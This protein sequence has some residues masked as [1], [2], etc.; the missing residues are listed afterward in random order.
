MIEKQKYAV[1]TL[2]GIMILFSIQ[3]LL[4]G[5]SLMNKTNGGDQE[6]LSLDTMP[7][8]SVFD[9]HAF[10]AI[11]VDDNAPQ[12]WYDKTHV[13]TIQEGIDVAAPGHI[14][15]VYP[16]I[17]QE[18]AP[19]SFKGKAITVQSIEGPDHTIITP[20]KNQNYIIKFDTDEQ[21]TSVFKGFT[22]QGN[23]TMKK[24]CGIYCEG[25]SP[26]LYGNVIEYVQKGILIKN[27]SPLIEKNLIR[28]NNAIQAYDIFDGYGG[29]ICIKSNHDGDFSPAIVWNTI[30][31]NS[32]EYCGGGIYIKPFGGKSEILISHTILQNNTADINGGGMH[33]AYVS[34]KLDNEQHLTLEFVNSVLYNNIAKNNGGGAYITTDYENNLTFSDSTITENIA[35]TMESDTDNEGGGIYI[36]TSEPPPGYSLPTM[37]LKNTILYFNHIGYGIGDELGY[38]NAIIHIIYSDIRGFTLNPDQQY[39]SYG[40]WGYIYWGSGVI[41]DD[42]CFINSTQKGYHLSQNSPCINAGNNA[43]IP[44]DILDLDHDRNISEPIPYDI[45]YD[46]RMIDIIV[47]I[48]AD[49]CYT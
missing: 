24:S 8:Q 3:P 19:L 9:P 25:S 44:N 7:Y 38:N 35:G 21:R 39:I 14:V 46:P 40:Q 16:G 23:E 33:I 29:G 28:N 18:E 36:K 42:P 11:Y 34:R 37:T 26:T 32:A 48:G 45:D 1:S 43:L 31:N 47:D 41:D 30:E 22:I 10:F 13:C 12:G 20:P 27:G 5:S 49:E 6:M 17:Y 4:Q 15:Y 2:F